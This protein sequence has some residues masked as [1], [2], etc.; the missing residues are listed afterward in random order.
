VTFLPGGFLLIFVYLVVIVA[1]I[2]L[3]I[4]SLVLWIQVARRWLRLHP[5]PRSKGDE[6]P[7]AD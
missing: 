2:V 4:W 7:A 3:G 5:A 1:A 6:P